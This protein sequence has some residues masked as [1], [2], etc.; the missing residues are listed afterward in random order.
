MVLLVTA[1][2]L[3]TRA[4]SSA[5]FAACER[6]GVA[7]YA[8]PMEA[9]GLPRWLMARARGLGLTLDEPAAALLADL[10]EGNLLAAAQELESSPCWRH[11]AVRSTATAC[12]TRSA[13]ARAT[14]RA[15]CP[16]PCSAATR[17]A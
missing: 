11:R 13:T 9:A 1:D 16:T 7:V 14:R 15:I 5:W 17:G 8:W 4:R 12:S 6:V 2:A 10:T 3:D